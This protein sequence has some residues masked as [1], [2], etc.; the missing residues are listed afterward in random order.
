MNETF[1]KLGVLTAKVDAAHKRIDN[2]EVG[3]RQDLKEIDLSI[4]ELSA[5]M[6]R[7]K[8]WGAAFIF[9]GG[10]SGAGLVKLLNFMFQ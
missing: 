5:Y 3:M 8:G 6:N 4:K 9:L 2:L 10:I 1:E 7:S